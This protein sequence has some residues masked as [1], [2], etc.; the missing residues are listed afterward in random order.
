MKARSNDSH[1]GRLDPVSAPDAYDPFAVARAEVSRRSLLSTGVASLLLGAVAC[2]NG[3][4]IV[5]GPPGPHVS[6]TPAPGGI[7]D[8]DILNFALNLEYLESEFYYYATTGKGIEAH[9]I[10]TGGTGQR[11][12]TTGGEKTDFTDAVT[13]TVAT[14]ITSDEGAHVILLRHAL[15]AKAIAKP[16]IDLSA[17]GIDMSKMV[18]FLQLS[19]AFED[20]GASAY[21]GAATLIKS[22]EI[23]ATAA[24]ILGTEIYHATNVRLMVAQMDI[25]TTKTDSRDVLPPP[26][27]TDYFCDHKALAVSRT[28]AEVI[29]IVAPFFPNGLNGRIT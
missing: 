2:T 5:P 9:G 8:I 6:P 10:P 3:T 21:T 25:Q 13:K 15:G 29:K 1:D 27:G 22:N 28:A 23:L 16:A 26:S 4:S 12:K 18:G 11:G 20:T 7:T 24:Q 17:A 14:Q 19:R